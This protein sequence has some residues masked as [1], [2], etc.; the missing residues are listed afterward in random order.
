MKIER[1]PVFMVAIYS[2][3]PTTLQLFVMNIVKQILK[4]TSI[5]DVD[6]F[7]CLSLSFFVYCFCLRLKPLDV[8]FMKRLHDKVNIIPLIA[9]ADTLTPDECR[10]FK[11]TVSLN[12][13]YP[14]P[15]TTPPPEYFSG[16]PLQNF[17][18]GLLII[19]QF[20]PWNH[21]HFWATHPLYKN[22]QIYRPLPPI[23]WRDANVILIK[24]S[25]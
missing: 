11:K 3:K 12:S 2:N 7:F 18:I 6:T 10:E 17:H 5:F 9:K 20:H 8:E 22:R 4:W 19:D 21:S 25:S 14:H 23:L 1:H 24:K 15:P 16:H 13:L